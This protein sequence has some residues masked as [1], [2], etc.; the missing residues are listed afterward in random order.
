M[1]VFD[2]MAWAK[3]QTT[4]STGRKAVLMALAERTGEEPVCYPS[5]SLLAE[6]TEQSERTVRTQL[7]D[8]VDAGLITV[9]R[10]AVNVHTGEPLTGRKGVRNHYR[11]MVDQPATSDDQPATEGSSNATTNRQIQHDQ[12]ANP[13]RP[14]GK[15]STTNRQPVAGEVPVVEV[16]SGTTIETSSELP[17]GLPPAAG[18]GDDRFEDF[19]ALCPKRTGK[20]DARRAWKAAV[21]IATPETI[22][23]GMAR[24]AAERA[25]ADPRYHKTPGPWLRAEMWT[26]EPGTHRPARSGPRPARMDTDREAPSGEVRR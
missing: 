10:R 15:S 5:Q 23:E 4:G 7:A 2:T 9:Q 17:L 1:S 22:I 21:K 25:E 13:A 12:P 26:D 24:Y 20:G 8:L 16:P 3:R 14:T 18:G 11:L 6:E 19:W